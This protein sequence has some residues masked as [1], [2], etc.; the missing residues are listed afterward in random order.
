[1]VDRLRLT[2]DQIA[3]FVGNDPQA[4]RQ[5]E[6]LFLQSDTQDAGLLEIALTAGI[7]D[8]K[9]NDALAILQRIADALETVAV[10]PL[11]QVVAEHDDLVPPK[12][13]VL[14]DD[15]VPP[16][17]MPACEDVFFQP[18]R[19]PV[20]KRY[21]GFYSTST[22]TA[23]LADTAYAVTFNTTEIAF[24]V[25]INSSSRVTP[26]NGGLFLL[27]YSIHLHET[28]GGSH[29]VFSWVRIN[30]ADVSYSGVHTQIEGNGTETSTGN[31]HILRLA[32][33]DYVEVMWATS[34]TA[35]EISGDAASAFAPACPSA[36][37]TITDSLEEVSP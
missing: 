10:A 15:I 2:R 27:D 29:D 30:G 1:M 23:A 20:A 19:Q 4:I 28:S 37:V 36:R 22:Q 13:I 17:A 6:K 14:H 18:P 7:A 34:S 35:I 12:P 32:R 24:G 16:V 5:I 26:D 33:G 25:S 21:G 9:A 3:R 31:R 11:P 8:G